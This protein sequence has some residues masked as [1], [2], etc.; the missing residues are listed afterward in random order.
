MIDLV[1]D[2]PARHVLRPY[3]ERD[4]YRIMSALTRRASGVLYCL[5]TGGGKTEVFTGITRTVAAE[6]W[7]V[8]TF[9]HRR[10]LIRQASEKLS[11]LGVR[12]GII[13]PDHTLTEDH[14]QVCSIDT[15][16][17]RISTLVDRLARVRLGIVDEAHHTVAPKYQ[18]VI[19]LL[20][21]AMLL[22]VTA[23]P[24]RLDGRGLGDDYSEAI[25]GPSV[26]EL[27]EMGFLAP[28]AVFAPPVRVD[29]SLVHRRGGDYV[30]GELARA[31]D[32][33]ELTHA[34][35]LNY[36][37]IC[38]GT[39]MIAF[40]AGIEHARHVAAQFSAEG[41][42]AASI[43]GEMPMARRDAAIHDLGTGR[44]HVLT[45][46]DIISEG[47][48]IPIVGGA[49]LLRPTK[50][51]ALFLQQI[52]RTL[53]LY[54]GKTESI[55]LDMVG[56]VAEHGMPTE[57]RP[58]SLSGGLKGIERAVGATRRCQ[59]CSYVCN[60]GP[61]RCPRCDT[62]YP[63][64]APL[65]KL[66]ELKLA[67]LGQIGGVSADRIARMTLVDILEVAHTEDELRLVQLIRGYRK[68]WVDHVMAE[69]GMRAGLGRLK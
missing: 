64:L 68:G 34:A 3:Q 56:N 63:P 44:L 35:V 24:F 12:H 46:V 2:A 22:G 37:R 42:A 50:S 29:L 21:N 33:P 11:R 32:N 38:P 4:T 60:A 25:D 58:W 45:S 8:W 5:P 54:Q 55:I 15:I 16:G 14:V 66:S 67:T 49:I 51:T 69:R 62:R 27:I 52:G 53:R 39:P 23:T 7:E 18:R 36:A 13:A 61:K 48:D 19:E 1:R 57:R 41:W 31:V 28:P 47:T 26:A 40:C 20:I 59:W 43:D 30:A 10:E 6:R 9:V 65:S 17:S